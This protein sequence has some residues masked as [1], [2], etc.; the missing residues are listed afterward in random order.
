[1]IDGIDGRAHYVRFRGV[2]AFADAPPAGG[3]V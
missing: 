2:E 3:I 1:V